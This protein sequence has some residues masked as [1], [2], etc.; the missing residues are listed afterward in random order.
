MCYHKKSIK[1]A[2]KISCKLFK[3]E[4]LSKSKISLQAL[5][6]FAQINSRECDSFSRAKISFKIHVVFKFLPV[7]DRIKIMCVCKL[8]DY[9][10]LSTCIYTIK[11]YTST[12][13]MF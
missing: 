4:L 7:V 9:K 10:L 6:G 8:K 12:L 1:T 11:F 3:H 13:K 2:F 5:S